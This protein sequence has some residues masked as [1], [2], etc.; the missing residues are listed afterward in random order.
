VTDGNSATSPGVAR[1][2]R[3]I[4]TTSGS[5]RRCWHPTARVTRRALAPLALAAVVTASAPGL[6]TVQSGDTLSGIAAAHGLSVAQLRELNGLPGSSSLIYAGQTLTVSGG[7]SSGGS[8]SGGSSAG[9]SHSVSPGET[10]SGIAARY[11]VSQSAI[12]QANGLDGAGTVYAGRSLV[13]PGAGG[14]AS[15]SSSGA[16]SSGASSSGAPSSGAPSSGGGGS[17]VTSSTA[18]NREI[19]RARPAPDRGQVQSMIRAAAQRRGVD[20]ALALAV[21][22]QESGFQHRIVS[23][24]NAVGVMQVLPGTAEWMSNVV[25]RQLDPLDLADNI[26]A[27]VALLRVLRD[28]VDVETA[29]AAYYQGLR[30][31]RQNGV[32]AETRQ[33]VAN[34]MALRAQY[35]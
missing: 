12:A 1:P 35:A 34:V 14:G 10:L 18:Q 32:Y 19:L 4:P 6:V 16:S 26:E 11:G 31:V 24:A 8:G 25:G 3:L 27:G 9:G 20:P 33:Y 23:P 17:A 22:H 28:Q 30:G 29:V 2:P 21:A 15:S 7:S 13:I 5:R